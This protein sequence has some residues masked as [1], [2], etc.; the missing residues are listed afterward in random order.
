MQLKLSPDTCGAHAE[1][2]EC[3]SEPRLLMTLEMI[4]GYDDVGICYCGAY[5]WGLAVFSV[6]RDFPVVSPFQAVRDDDIRMCGNRIEA[7]VHCGPEM[8]Y[9]I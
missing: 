6:E 2:L 9:C 5:L 3:A 4:H 7:I 8:V 1:I